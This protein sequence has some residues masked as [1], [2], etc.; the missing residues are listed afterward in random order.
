M[1]NLTASIGDLICKHKKAIMG[2][3][4]FLIIANILA[5]YYVK[6]EHLIYYWDQVNYWLKFKYICSHIFHPIDILRTLFYSIREDDYNYLPAF[7]LMPFGVLFGTSRVAFILSIVNILVLSATISFVI[8]SNKLKAITGHATSYIY[9][10]AMGIA[11]LIPNY[12]QPVLAGLPDIGGVLLANILLIIYLSS[13][14][15][16]I[17]WPQLL[18]IAI[19]IPVLILFRRWY[20]YWGVAFFGAYLIEE[21]VMAATTRQYPRSIYWKNIY[22]IL[23]VA[24]IS[25]VSVLI[26]APTFVHR[27]IGTSYSDIYSYSRNSDNL[28]QSF[29]FLFDRFG[30]FYMTLFMLGA[31]FAVK[32][33][34]TRRFSIFLITQWLIIFILFSRTQ[35]FDIQHLYLLMPTMMILI[36][37]FIT[38]WLDG[39][40]RFRPLIISG[41]IFAVLMNFLT[42]FSPKKGWYTKPFPWVYTQ[43]SQPPIVRNDIGEIDRMLAALEH[44][45]ANPDQKVYV[46]ASSGRFNCQILSLAYLSI[47]RHVGI[48]NHIL[49]TNDVDKRDGFPNQFLTA[50]YVIITA[51]IQYHARPEDQRIVG[52]PAE[53]IES[54]KGIGKAY[55]KLPYVFNLDNNVKAY[56]YEKTMPLR[57]VDINALSEQLR[58]YYPD[59]PNIYT[60]TKS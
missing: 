54:Q 60:I 21:C 23:V 12:W 44:L 18:A 37:L 28:G 11:L 22:R 26:I 2:Y 7:L 6:S 43:F 19:L 15:Q 53:L 27:I 33:D 1:I 3:G 45:V 32:N 4:L 47:G 14:R 57:D 8:L 9:Y 40:R 55:K 41:L 30:L 38:Y 56:I 51:P 50:K 58:T 35:D 42:A 10:I 5:Y 52:I 16:E 29:M 24:V 34:K 31:A 13:Y 49:W 20:L 48:A 25:G 39:I 36:V 17:R 46:L 59:K